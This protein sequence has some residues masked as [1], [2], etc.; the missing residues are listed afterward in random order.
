MP[1]NAQLLPTSLVDY[2]Q[3]QSLTTFLINDTIA[4]DAPRLGFSLGGAELANIE[5]VILTH[6][7]PHH[8]QPRTPHRRP[9]RPDRRLRRRLYLRHLRHPGHL[10]RRQPAHPPPRRLRRLLLPRRTR[11][12]RHPLRP[13]HPAPGHRRN[14]QAH[15]P[16]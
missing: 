14:R 8:R 2:S 12:P 13:P 16:R 6:P 11:R 5:H 4:V 1:P 9:R 15:P 10:G 3:T 7:P